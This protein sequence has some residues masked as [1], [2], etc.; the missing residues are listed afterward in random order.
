[1]LVLGG[2][3]G[4]SVRTIL[5]GRQ[6][7]QM[8]KGTSQLVAK[9]KLIV[10]LTRGEC[11]CVSEMADGPLRRMRGLMGRRGLPAGEGLLIKP[12]PAIHTGFM[13]FP[14]DALFLDR[15]LE[16]LEIVERLPPW[17]FASKRHARA[18]LELS[19]GEC[20]RRGVEVGDK[21]ELRERRPPRAVPSRLEDSIGADGVQDETLSLPAQGGE[22]ARLQPLRLLVVSPDRRFR[23][24]MSLLLARR[25]CSVT[26][27]ANASRVTELIVR[28]S[29]DVVLL[30]TSQLPAAST[31]ATVSMVAAL[32]RPVGIV[33]VADDALSS[34]VARPGLSDPPVLAKWGP[35]E[36]LFEAI[37]RVDER[38]GTWGDIR[39][40]G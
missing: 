29:A 17:R 20:A 2:R 7:W 16:V 9:T 40:R 28:E 27:T 34:E 26:T 35:F 19:A 24:V 22:L 1:M 13:R 30:D 36:D 33:L 15:D 21:L 31:T 39:A 8:E 38:R 14:I 23:T 12:A 11:V 4:S 18:V 37:E 3:L 10:N 25:N 5:S 6:R 32:A